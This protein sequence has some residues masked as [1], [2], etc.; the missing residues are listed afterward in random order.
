MQTSAVRK[1]S[2]REYKEPRPVIA[3]PYSGQMLHPFT[4]SDANG[5]Q[6]RLWDYR[7]RSNLVLFF[8]H[9]ADCPACRSMLQELAAH[10]ATYRAEKATVLAIGP[11]QPHAALELAAELECPFLLLSDPAERIVAQQGFAVPAVVVAD[12][13]G[14]I[15]A[16][17][18]GE[19]DHALPSGQEIAAWLAFMEVQCPECDPL[20]WRS[21]K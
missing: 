6:V 9:G 14:E 21:F 11:D 15:W 3:D 1:E 19:D 8:H 18:I 17:W 12:R 7:Q 20:A 13:F 16:A 4:L 5:Q 2:G 10:M